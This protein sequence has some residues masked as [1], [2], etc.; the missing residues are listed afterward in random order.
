[1]RSILDH[2]RDIRWIALNVAGLAGSAT[3]RLPRASGLLVLQIPDI[4]LPKAVQNVEWAPDI[5]P[6][7]QAEKN[8]D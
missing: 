5:N 8:S 6:A 7:N 3:R 2:A 4:R 1:M